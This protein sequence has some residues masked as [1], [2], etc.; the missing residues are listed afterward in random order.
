[1]ETRVMREWIHSREGKKIASIANP[2]VFIIHSAL[3][4]RP[5]QRL[6]ETKGDDIMYTN[7]GNAQIK[8]IISNRS[9]IFLFKPYFKFNVGKVNVY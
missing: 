3:S 1:M 2:L 5:M 6:R 8:L 7:R 4:Y 9:L